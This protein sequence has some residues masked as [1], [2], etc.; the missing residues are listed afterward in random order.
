MRG[1]GPA[2]AGLARRWLALLPLLLLAGCGG[3]YRW[4]WYV[5][6]PWNETGLENL[7]YLASGLGY[8]LG[9]STLSMAI[10]V[11]T[12]LAVAVLGL[13][14]SR[15]LRLVHRSYV[16]AVRAIPV[17]VLLLWVYYGLPVVLAIHLDAFAAAVLALAVSDSA[18]EAEIFRA[19][20]QSIGRG[21]REAADALGLKRWQKMWFVILPQA[22]RR[23]LPPLGNQFVYM[24]KMSALA[25]VIGLPELTRRANELVVSLYRPL[26]IYSLLVLEY[27]FLI[28]LVSS[29]V[30]GLERRLGAA[31]RTAG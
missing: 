14:R 20:I 5:V 23:I 2:A 15:V 25:S 29:L 16:E 18:F 22:I 19:G 13:A 30:R 10:S 28:L 21:Q 8:T 11:P 24:L 12:G 27:L 26:E 31:E 9:L 3:S 6:S 7:R 1:D 4:G 17:L